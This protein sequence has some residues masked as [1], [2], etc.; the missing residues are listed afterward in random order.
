MLDTNIYYTSCSWV[1]IPS[2]LTAW[3][4]SQVFKAFIKADKVKQQV[5]NGVPLYWGEQNIDEPYD[6]GN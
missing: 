3:D 4:N 5:V 6:I 1:H 2:Y